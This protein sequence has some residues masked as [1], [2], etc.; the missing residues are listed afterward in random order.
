[1]NQRQIVTTVVALILTNAGA[2]LG[3]PQQTDRTSGNNC[4]AK[5]G[6]E[7][8]SFQAVGP[9]FM[10]LSGDGAGSKT[11]SCPIEFVSGSTYYA[12]LVYVTRASGTI[13]CSLVGYEF[14][15]TFVA[16]MGFDSKSSGTTGF[17]GIGGTVSS[18][19]DY[20]VMTCDL[21]SGSSVDSYVQ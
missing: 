6:S 12:I 15:G 2:A 18:T 4:R 10:R 9:R 13:S 17:L 7:A 1:M 20:A 8:A 5:N 3:N 14:D 11:V 16:N 19:I 21:T